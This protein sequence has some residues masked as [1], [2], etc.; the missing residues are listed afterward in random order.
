[1]HMWV[2]SAGPQF[3]YFFMDTTL[4]TTTSIAL[5]VLLVVLLVFY[6]LFCVLHQVLDHL[7]GGAVLHG[8]AV[9]LISSAVCRFRD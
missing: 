7:G 6:G 1:M 2:P 3:L 5:V 8:L 4:G 9:V